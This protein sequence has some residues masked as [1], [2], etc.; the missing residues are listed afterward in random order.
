MMRPKETRLW[1]VDF[2]TARQSESDPDKLDASFKTV[3]VTGYSIQEALATGMACAYEEFP[4]SQIWVHQ[5]RLV[6]K[7]VFECDVYEGFVAD[8]PEAHT[9][10]M[11]SEIEWEGYEG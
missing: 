11:W 4:G 8:N 3:F 9:A 1:A 2:I 5:I 6:D 7:A 10:A